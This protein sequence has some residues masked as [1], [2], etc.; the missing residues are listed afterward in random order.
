MEKIY[1]VVIVGSGAAGLYAALQFDESVRVLVIAKRE[2]SLSNSSLAQGG[3]A[4]VLDKDNDNFKLHIADTLIA[5]KYKN[6]P[7]AIEV[8]VTEGPQDVL[9]LKKL[10]VAFDLDNS[11]KLQMTLEAGHSRHR[12][13]HH[14]DSTGK[15]I[16]DVL[17]EN[18]KLRRNVDIAQNTM[19]YDLK[20][21]DGG[22]TAYLL[23]DGQTDCVNARYCI[24]ATGGVG[25]VYAYTT[26]SAIATGDGITMAHNLGAKIKH[27]SWIQFHPTAFA[28]EKDRER[29]LIS[30]A[31]RGE[32][33]VLLNCKGERFAFDYDERGE[34]APRD[35]VSEAIMLEAKKTNSEN[36]YLDITHKDPESVRNRFPMIYAKCLE[37]NVDITK[38]RIPVFPCQH[39]LM[40]GI[41]VDLNA[42]STID[43]LYAAGEC[44]HTGVHGANRL[45]SNSLLEALV[46]SR[47]AAEDIMRRLKKGRAQLAVP[48]TPKQPSGAQ[49]PHGYRTE[50]REI[51]QSAHFVLPTPDAVPEGLQRAKRILNE[52]KCSGYM[53][54]PDLVEAKSLATVA[55]IIL[56]ELV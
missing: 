46:F 8:L 55:C 19:L 4:A 25:R 42:Q 13:V 23:K 26:N 1:D 53:L 50:I 5:G 34:L 18:V 38:D 31:V 30:E 49:L 9:N 12:I 56:Q 41:D 29:F 44:S 32:G 24:M 17:I 52:L 39:Y 21:V 10:G 28:A 37:E 11:G 27:L 47:R 22:F 48:E 33:A 7:A 54:T 14:K 16:T 20:K 15:A 51:M 3:V 40:G 6:D 2:L 35:V 45:A 36:F 43:G